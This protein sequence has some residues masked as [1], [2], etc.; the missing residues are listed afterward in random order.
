MVGPSPTVVSVFGVDPH[1]I[2]SGEIYARE[3]SAQLG[4]RGW[5]SVLCYAGAPPAPV[6]EFLQLPNVS[7]EVV[8]DSWKISWK[9]VRQLS[10]ILTKY[11]PE[12]LHL[13]FT[14]FLSAYPW[15]ARMHATRDV[16]FSDHNSR[17]EGY[18]PTRRPVWK[19]LLMRGINHPISKV[20]CVSGYGFR[21][22]TTLDLLP[23]ERFAMI[24][25]GVDVARA[26][27]GLRQR[28]AFRERYGIGEDRLVV[29]QVSWLI[30]Q[31]GVGDLL[32]AAR[33]VIAQEPRA[34]FVL[35]G[36]GSHAAEYKRTAAEWGLSDHVT[37]TGTVM[38]PLAEGVYAAADVACQVSRWEECCAYV[39]PEAMASY[40]PVVGTRVGGTP[41][42]IEDGKTGFLAERGDV[43]G[44]AER[45]LLL[46][47]DRA[48]REEM[49]RAGRRAAENKFN[50]KLHVAQM[51]ELYG[52]APVYAESVVVG[53]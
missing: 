46:L 37:F 35:A 9:A 42:L 23:K 49:G 16:Y 28:A 32:A 50:H 17:P 38:D 52:L 29:T 41:E 47:R 45:L 8:E 18:V 48:R 22:F 43:P 33:I 12:I 34:H 1:R 36:D 40:L 25:N 15:L 27:A 26:A 24:Y 13:H 20:I 44:I 51:L 39:I 3:L 14:G 7:L 31:K 53:R 4:E 21:C 11:R 10:R 6:H 2:S 5:K 19:R 30:P